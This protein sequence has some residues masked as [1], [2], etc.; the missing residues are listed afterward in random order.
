MKRRRKRKTGDCCICG[1][2]G[3]LT[4]EHVPPKQA[5]NK[6]RTVEYTL[7]DVLTSGKD[8]SKR[9]TKQGGVKF[10]TLCEKCNNDTGSWYAAEYASWATIGFDIISNWQKKEQTE[11]VVILHK[12]YPLR[13]LKQCATC[14]FSVIGQYSG[15]GF[16]Q[17]NPDL[18]SFVLDKNS[19][20][21]PSQYRFFMDLY[22]ISKNKPTILQRL[23]FFGRLSV[24]L[25]PSGLIVGDQ[26]PI[27]PTEM[28]HPPFRIRMTLNG[29]LPESTEIT[30][31]AQYAYDEE[32]DVSLPLRIA[33]S[34][35]T[36]PSR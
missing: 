5:Y 36:L 7:S 33:E 1:K 11:G 18:V 32:V 10:E 4:Q 2:N 13:F 8:S 20:I 12:V 9:K 29:D 27:A 6:I 19:Q 14:M 21:L 22:P 17:N 23:P 16:A 3:L 24:K 35:G 25:T 28:A 15:A 26:S 34:S 31:F 30:S